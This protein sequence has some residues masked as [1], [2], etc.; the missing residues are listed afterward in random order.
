MI[1]IRAEL[2]CHGWPDGN[3]PHGH[4]DVKVRGDRVDEEDTRNTLLGQLDRSCFLCEEDGGNSYVEFSLLD[5]KKG[6]EFDRGRAWAVVVGGE[7]DAF[8]LNP[9]GTVFEN[10]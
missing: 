7:G 2:Y 10:F 5:E 6:D 4:V 9:V 1:L 8:V 3:I